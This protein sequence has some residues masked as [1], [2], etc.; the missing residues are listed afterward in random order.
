[1]K[2]HSY[3]S[4]ALPR[5]WAGLALAACAV[6]AAALHAPD[7]AAA[8]G[9]QCTN[10]AMQ[11]DTAW[12]VTTNFAGIANGVTIADLTFSHSVKATNTRMNYI[13]GLTVESPGATG[14]YQTVPLLTFPGLGLRWSWQ[15]YENISNAE[16]NTNYLR[17]VG[18]V[19]TSYGQEWIAAP[20]TTNV[21]TKQFRA[22]WKLELVVTDINVYAGGVGNFNNESGLRFMRVTPTIKDNVA[23]VVLQACFPVFSNLADAMR[24]GGALALPEL[25]KPPTPT[26][27][28]PVAS[29]NQSVPLNRGTTGS[30]PA[31][32]A[33][34]AEGAVGETPFFINA[35]NCGADSNYALYFTDANQAGGNK[36]YLNSTGAQA[37]KV[38]L[39]MYSAGST[40]PVQFGPPPVGG[41][42]PAYAAGVTNSGTAAGSSFNHPLTVQY[43]R[44]PGYAGALTADSLAAQATVTVVY[45]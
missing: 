40:V 14:P 17:P 9:Q 23:P 13:M 6:T 18:S 38:N 7:A 3:P 37:G 21:L 35:V 42:Q 15:G 20:F 31:N 8:G 1:M 39:R 12:R 45:P 36:E 33:G 32:G 16:V 43:V 11:A 26:C 30:V 10:S 19:V 24:Q 41:S 44:A 2:T 25:P 28:F 4:S 27:Q 34:R 29:L 5:R 22:K